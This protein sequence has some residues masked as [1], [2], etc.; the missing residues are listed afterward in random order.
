MRAIWEA[1]KLAFSNMTIFR[2]RANRREFGLFLVFD[3]VAYLLMFSITYLGS[4]HVFSQIINFPITGI[5]IFLFIP[6][7]SIIVRRFHDIEWHGIWRIFPFFG[8]I[9]LLPLIILWLIFSIVYLLTGLFGLIFWIFFIGLLPVHLFQLHDGESM[10][11]VIL[12]IPIVIYVVFALILCC[13]KSQT[14]PNK[15]GEPSLNLYSEQ[16]FC[17]EAHD[18]SSANLTEP[19]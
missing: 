10:F 17:A 18:N 4:D 8:I 5:G 2:G 11:Y 19:K 7:V 9:M 6:S 15:Y 12:I 14:G 1:V 16:Y 3:L 13:L